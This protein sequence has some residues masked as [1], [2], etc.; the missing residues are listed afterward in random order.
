MGPSNAAGSV[1]ASDGGAAGTLLGAL[2][3]VVVDASLFPDLVSG[4][5]QLP[6][7]AV[8]ERI[9]AETVLSAA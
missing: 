2:G 6:V 1:T 8:A 4:G 5:L 7:M 9:V 3:A